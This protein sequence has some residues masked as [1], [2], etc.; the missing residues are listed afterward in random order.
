L[1]Q[2]VPARGGSKLLHMSALLRIA[3]AGAIVGGI[4]I[5]IRRELVAQRGLGYWASVDDIPVVNPADPVEEFDQRI[6]PAAP[7]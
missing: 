1:A 3:L 2:C 7:L 5:A 6:A 4:V